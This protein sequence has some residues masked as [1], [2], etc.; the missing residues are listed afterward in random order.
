MLQWHSCP[1]GGGVTIPGGVPEPWRCGTEECGHGGVVGVGDPR[2]LFQPERFYD[3][4]VLVQ[5]VDFV[6]LSGWW[7]HRAGQA[8]LENAGLVLVSFLPGVMVQGWGEEGLV[9]VGSPA[10]YPQVYGHPI[11]RYMVKC[12]PSPGC[13]DFQTSAPGICQLPLPS[14]WA[15]LWERSLLHCRRGTLMETQGM[16]P[17]CDGSACPICFP[18][19][20]VF[21]S[22]GRMLSG[23][24]LLWER[25]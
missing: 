24:A 16:G 19:I 6:G 18:D 10:S 17:G 8:C 23:V 22:A 15:L 1:C 7:W 11:L 5:V 4:G 9:A 13:A 3:P 12:A 2:G 21:A 20:S 25:R 14:C